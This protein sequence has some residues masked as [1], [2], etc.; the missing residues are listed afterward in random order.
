[1]K[2]LFSLLFVA[3]LAMS[4]WAD[5]VVTVD[6]NAQGW[7]TN[8]LVSTLTVDD[9]TLTFDKGDG[10]T[11]PTYFTNTSGGALRL[12]GG[13]TMT[14][15][16][17]Q[18]LKKIDFTFATGDGNNDIM[19][20]VGNYNKA[21]KQWTIG[22]SDPSTTVV[23]TIDGNSG[24]RRIQQLVI[25]FEDAEPVTELV[26]PQFHPNGGEFTG[27]LAVT[28][29]CATDNA[30]IYVYKVIDGEVDYSTGMY[31]FESGEFYVTE[32]MTYAAYAEKG[33][34]YTDFVY[35]TFTKVEQTVEAPVFTPAAGP[36]MDRIEVTLACA[37]PNAK[38]Y[39]SLDNELWSEYVDPIPVT[40]DITIWAKAQ[41]G[42]VESEVVSATYT[43]LPA[44]TVDV[45]FDGAVDKGDGDN[46]RHHFTVVKNPVTMY[47][48][49]GLVHD[50]GHYR[51]YG[52][53]DSS[54]LVFTSVGAPIIK[55]EFNGMS[56]YTASN[57][58]KAEG[59]EGTWT[60]G[61]TDG[62][63][64]GYA[65]EVAFNVNKQARFT[66]IIV[67]VAGQEEPVYEI[68]DVNRDGE[69]NIA[70]ATALIDLLLANSA[71]EYDAIADVNSD[72]EVNIADVTSL[73]DKLLGVR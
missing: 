63:W 33:D 14:V 49:D 29:S 10:G 28:V 45:T 72:G 5:T 35:A 1:M 52:P 64:E 40:D 30:S 44:T 19:S 20:N 27:S 32:T 21:G 65:N 36:F 51:I 73:I 48:G 41:V 70:D 58:S 56:G 55:I 16:A 8:T 62:T 9:V 42:D 57:L 71:V 68:G 60:T 47:V 59:N 24:H 39:Y 38:I 6:F 12:Y 31:F 69:V 54:A 15:T 3:L 7:E 25:T 2:K 34:D 66:T 17:P 50:S 18:N 11:K 22:S 26:A 46:T 13:N 53:N 43:K 61:G 23:F 67:T 37:T 4:A